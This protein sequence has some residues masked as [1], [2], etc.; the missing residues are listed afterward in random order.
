MIVAPIAGL[1][2]PRVGV[3]ALLS[4]GLTLQSVALVWLALVIQPGT[5]YIELVPGFLLAG[6]GM[7]LTFAPSSTAVLADMADDDHG[8]ASSTN[9]TIREIGVALGR[10]GAGRGL[11]GR[12]RHDQPGGLRRRPEAGDPD[13]CRGRGGR[14]GRAPLAAPTGAAEAASRPARAVLL[15]EAAPVG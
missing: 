15:A 11:R 3:R 1:L 4:V 10:G 9:A 5:A 14:C 12:R 13:R 6:I 8:T 7:G 2:A